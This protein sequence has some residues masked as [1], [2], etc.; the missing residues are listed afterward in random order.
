[1]SRTD[2]QNGLDMVC[3]IKP[4]C[5]VKNIYEALYNLGIAN[6]VI[7]ILTL[8]DFG[9]LYV[10]ANKIGTFGQKLAM[11]PQLKIT[12]TFNNSFIHSFINSIKVH[13]KYKHLVLKLS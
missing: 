2:A 3:K 6:N 8:T 13:T 10:L 11:F 9:Y 4:P 1:M 5:N 7:N 12:V